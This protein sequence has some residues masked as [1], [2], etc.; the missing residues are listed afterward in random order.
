MAGNKN[1]R[2]YKELMKTIQ[3]TKHKITII[4]SINALKAGGLVIANEAKRNSPYYTGNL[5]RSIH[6]LLKKVFG[7]T[8]VRC[9]IGTNEKYGKYV[10][11]G[12]GIYAVNGDGRKTPWIAPI[13]TKGKNSKTIFR[14]TNGRRPKPFL[15]PALKQKYAEAMQEMK[16]VYIIQF[17]KVVAREAAKYGRLSR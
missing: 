15:E 6:V 7:M 3:N 4:A 8:W 16:R 13:Q 10:E 1:V 5:R 11:R 14:W 17:L 9:L 12:T 2:G